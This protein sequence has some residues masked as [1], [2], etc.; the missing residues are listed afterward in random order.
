VV[1]A[2][3]GVTRLLAELSHDTALGCLWLG[4]SSAAV[5]AG[6]LAVHR[7]MGRMKEPA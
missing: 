2:Y 1:A 4:V 6:L 3:V 5:I 7:R